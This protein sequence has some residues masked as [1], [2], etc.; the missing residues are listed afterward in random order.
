[1]FAVDSGI[2]CNRSYVLNFP[3]TKLHGM[4]IQEFIADDNIQ[5]RIAILH[6]SPPC[7][8]FSPAKR[9]P[10]KD[11]EA[12]LQA[13]YTVQPLLQ[14]IRTRVGTI[15]QIAGLTWVK[16]RTQFHALLGQI[17]ALGYSVRWKVEY[18]PN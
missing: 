8:F 12:N 17:T 15:E 11:D 13:L 9:Y 2:G 18:L 16:H 14:K 4:N 10:G 3:G 1:M 6:I 7:Q 5:H